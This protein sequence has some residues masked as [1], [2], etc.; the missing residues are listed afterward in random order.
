MRIGPTTTREE[1]L[2]WEPGAAIAAVRGPQPD[3]TATVALAMFDQLVAAQLSIDTVEAS[4][5]FWSRAL[6]GLNPGAV[7]IER[8]RK[9]DFDLSLL[10]AASTVLASWSSALRGIVATAHDLDW[11]IRF[12][13]QVHQ[14]WKMTAAFRG[15]STQA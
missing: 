6:D 13:M 10:T 9:L 2:D 4:I 12:L 14:A 1:R 8:L 15:R 3:E 5:V 11:A 7:P